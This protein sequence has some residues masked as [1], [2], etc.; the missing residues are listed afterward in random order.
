M[1]GSRTTE[2]FLHLK[3]GNELRKSAHTSNYYTLFINNHPLWKDYP[4]R[5]IICSGG[6]GERA[7]AH[8]SRT[9]YYVF[10]ID[11]SKIGICPDDDIWSSFDDQ[12]LRYFEIRDVSNLDQFNQMLDY[13]GFSDD[14]WQTFKKQLQTEE[15]DVKN[16]KNMNAMK[17]LE[18]VLNPNKNGFK[19]ETT[20]NLSLNS[21]DNQEVWLDSEC[22][23]VSYSQK[24]KLENLFRDEGL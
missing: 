18:E 10:P 7:M 23:L 6:S 17:L 22:I 4:K 1:R 24:E 5:Q 16:N 15:I 13:Y 11:R 19:V 3:P 2:D 8:L 9:V 12:I 14:N 20:N 21:L